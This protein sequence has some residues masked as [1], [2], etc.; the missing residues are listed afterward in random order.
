MPRANYKQFF[1]TFDLGG[2]TALQNANVIYMALS[3]MM[4]VSVGMRF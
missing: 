2:M 3:R 4:N 1:A